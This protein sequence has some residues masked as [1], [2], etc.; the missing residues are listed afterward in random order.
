M[1]SSR[2]LRV[3]GVYSSS[4][5]GH[6]PTLLGH[7]LRSLAAPAS[8]KHPRTQATR[9][10]RVKCKCHW[11][12]RSIGPGAQGARGKGGWEKRKNQAGRPNRRRKTY[13]KVK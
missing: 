10:P 4:G 5:T 7:S 9:R 1:G 6:L 3:S 13:G 2:A 11:R 8:Q 12:P